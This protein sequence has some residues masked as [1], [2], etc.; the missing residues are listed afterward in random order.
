MP[1]GEGC[2]LVDELPDRAGGPV[3]GGLLVAGQL[4]LDDPLHAAR[5]EDDRHADE[6]VA[7]S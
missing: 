1:S 2:E 5:A 7:S 6:Q 4:D 3:E